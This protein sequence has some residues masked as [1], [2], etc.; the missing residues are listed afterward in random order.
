MSNQAAACSKGTN[1]AR[2]RKKVHES[3][4]EE[5]VLGVMVEGNGVLIRTADALILHQKFQVPFLF[6]FFPLRLCV[7]ALLR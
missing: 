5:L 2:A 4:R 7:F 3:H 1:Q 6:R